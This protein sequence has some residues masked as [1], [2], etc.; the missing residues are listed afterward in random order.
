[1]GA[2]CDS[3]PLQSRQD[4]AFFHRPRFIGTIGNESVQRLGHGS[5][6][7]DLVFK[8]K[9]LFDGTRAYVAATGGITTAQDEQLA[10]LCEREPA[11]LSLLDEAD[12]PCGILVIEPVAGRALAC[13]LDQPLALVIPERVRGDFR[14]RRKLADGEHAGLQADFAPWR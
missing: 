2:L 1:M 4:G 5:H 8:L 10:Y 11:V 14:E 13:R 7:P 3:D 12:A 9:F 6:R